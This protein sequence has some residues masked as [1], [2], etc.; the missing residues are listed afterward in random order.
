MGMDSYIWTNTGIE[1]IVYFKN[2]MREYPS[3]IIAGQQ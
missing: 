3:T 2:L 1:D